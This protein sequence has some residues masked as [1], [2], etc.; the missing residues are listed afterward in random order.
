MLVQYKRWSEGNLQILHSKYSPAWYAYGK[1]SLGHQLGYLRY[2]FWAANCWAT[3]VYSI[4]PSLYLLRGTSLFP[5]ISRSQAWF[6]PFVYVIIGKYT[7]S[8]VEFLWCGGTTLA[9]VITAKVADEDV[10]QRHKKEIMEFG[11]SSNAYPIANTC[12]AQFVTA[13]LGFLRKQSMGRA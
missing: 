9:F 5:Q 8:F 2:S 11:D 7:W 13:L 1:I 6:I 12:I 10:S 3:L 4:L